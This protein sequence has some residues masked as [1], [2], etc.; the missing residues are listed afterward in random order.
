MFN[1]LSAFP[2]TPL[3]NGNVDEKAFTALIET[4]VAAKVD[5]IGALGSTGSYAYL[6]RAQRARVA[7]L[8]TAAAGDV[9]VVVSI[10]AVNIDD[11]L[12]LAEDAQQAGVSGVLMAPVSY[13][14]LSRDEVY[15]LY[16]RVSQAVAVPLCVYDN[17]ATTRFSFDDELLIAVCQLPNIGSLKLGPLSGTRAEASAR[18][19]AL[20]QAI[21]ETITLGISGDAHA[22]AGL[23]AGC[24]VWYSVLAGLFPHAARRL[25]QAAFLGREEE[26]ARLNA[27]LAP[28]WA[29]FQRYGSLRP[30]ATLAELSGAVQ[31]PCLPFPLR[32]LQGEDRE[33]LAAL[34]SGPALRPE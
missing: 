12:R 11:V 14:P 30:I 20:R 19:Q 28:L 8:A 6:S 18:L 26:V 21:P 23:L 1:G 24:D 22:A 32:T 25:S 10:G 7:Q 17:P 4:L 9:P 31:P 3:V 27:E 33:Q 5:A 2:L 15:R 16:E 13:Q 29:L 34:L